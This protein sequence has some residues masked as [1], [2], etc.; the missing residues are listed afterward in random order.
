MTRNCFG[1]VALSTVVSL[2]LLSGCQK[3]PD[4]SLAT[5]APCPT[6]ETVDTAAI[7]T[8]LL[9]IEN[10]WPRIIKDHDA[11]GVKR[12]EAD[13]AF[14][15]YP[16]GTVGNK[17]TDV[18]DMERAAL[19]ADSWELSELRVTVLSK[20]TAT[21]S[22]HS[23]VKNGKYKGPTGTIDISGQYRFIDTFV[24]R[25]GEWKQVAGATVPIRAPGATASPAT[26][27]SPAAAA[28]P[29]T[30]PSP[31]AGA[32]PAVRP[33]PRLVVPPRV[34]MSPVVRPTP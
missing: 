24:K 17:T 28:S 8:E 9:L 7:E 13:D 2:V 14:F 29:A 23:T 20:D 10:D 26:S 31:A 19:T 4:T 5:P 11:E 16:D 15:I 1:V 30:R 21:V 25:S 27:P 12:V 3:T 18:Q 34:T 33:S 22:G 6:A 32:S